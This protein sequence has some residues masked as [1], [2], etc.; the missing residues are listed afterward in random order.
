MEILLKFK[1]LVSLSDNPLVVAR[2]LRKSESGLIE[3]SEYGMK[4][5]RVNPIREITDE[6]KRE[7]ALRTVYCKGI[8]KSATLDELLKVFKILEMLKKSQ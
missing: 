1:R 5:K 7:I 8:N 6:I 4:I 3:V 2:A